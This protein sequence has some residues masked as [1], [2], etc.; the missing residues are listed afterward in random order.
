[1]S[2]EEIIKTINVNLDKIKSLCTDDCINKTVVIDPLEYAIKGLLDL[3][4]K[5]KEKNE[6]LLDEAMVT[7]FDDEE[8]KKS[9]ANY[10]EKLLEKNIQKDYIS[11]DKIRAKIEPKLKEL[12]KEIKTEYEVYG[13]SKELQDL[14]DIYNFLIDIKELLEE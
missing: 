7:Y 5:E 9:I 2:E 12:D 6:K 1:M 10:L 8:I 4:N 14:E 11:K 13:N 3:Y